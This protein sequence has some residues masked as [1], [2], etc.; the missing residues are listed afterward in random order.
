[1][2]LR[3]FAVLSLLTV[4]GRLPRRPAALAA[5]AR[6]ARR[7]VRGLPTMRGEELQPALA[8]ALGDP[9]SSS[10]TGG[11]L[12]RYLDT[13][14]RRWRSADGRRA[15]G[16]RS[17]TTAPS[18]AV[19]DASLDDDPELIE[20]VAGAAIAL[21]H[22]RLHVESEER[23][24]QLR[25]SRERIVTA[26][27]DERRRLERNLHDG[28][29]QR[30]VALAMQLRLIQHE[31]HADPDAAE[32]LVDRGQ[33]GARDVARGAARA[34]ARDPPRGAQ[35]RPRA[36]AAVA[37]RPGD[38]CRPRWSTRP[39]ARCPEPVELAAY[40][41]TSEALANVGEVR[42][43]ASAT[44]RVTRGDG[45]LARRG[46][47]RRRRRRRRRTRGSGL[48]GLDRPRRGARRHA[49]RRQP[50]RAGHRRASRSCHA[51]RDRRRQPARARGHRLAAAARR[52]RG[53]GRGRRRR[54]RCV[55][56]GRR[57]QAR[58]RDRR[59]P[60]AAD[61]HRGGPAT[62]RARCASATRRSG[63]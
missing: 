58:R 39:R 12:Q 10:S 53:R 30:L 15:V 49:A 45:G 46:R 55:R 27:D 44:V 13:A 5:R 1:M 52:R 40:F 59:R 6:R 56:A 33:R 17:T 22:E 61:P 51:G 11:R 54:R 63:S 9:S 42:G 37:R 26:G 7:P 50:A 41:V 14:A 43:A 62:R 28:A 19:Y 35:P 25:A 18:R 57:A 24:A 34:R 38:R 32:Q 29:Q 23:L 4:P 21:E 16:R 60:D 47:R 20:A 3:W 36:G 2:W 8:R 48:R 31:L